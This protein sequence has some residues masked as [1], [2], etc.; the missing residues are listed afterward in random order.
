MSVSTAANP[1]PLLVPADTTPEAARVQFAALRRLTIDRRFEI[2]DANASQLRRLCEA[3]VRLRH[4]DYSDADARIAVMRL[5][6]GEECFC[7]C[8][9]ELSEIRP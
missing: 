3:G 2:A 7:R 1:Y 4:P 9:P 8:L 6:I 5:L